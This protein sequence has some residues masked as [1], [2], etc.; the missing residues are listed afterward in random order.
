MSRK[1]SSACG[2]DVAEKQALPLAKRLSALV[3]DVGELKD[4]LGV[5]VQ[6][7]SQYL[8]GIC[9]PSIENLAKIADFYQ[10]STDYL[11]GRTA[12]PSS[13]PNV[14]DACCYTGLSQKAADQLH[15]KSEELK[16]PY[17]EMA[18]LNEQICNTAFWNILELLSIYRTQCKAVAS[19]K[20]MI[21]NSTNPSDIS[22]YK[23]DLRQATEDKDLCLFR[24]QKIIFAIAKDIEKEA[25]DNGK[26]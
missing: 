18:E 4:Y 16:S 6:A 21:K 25:E 17:F 11:L 3:T 24:I 1:K 23:K 2:L 10:V 9:K 8:L 20:I 19:R 13:N 12:V 5:S 26:H 15:E 22:R 7:V 14:K